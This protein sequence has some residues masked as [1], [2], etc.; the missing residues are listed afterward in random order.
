MAEIGLDGHIYLRGPLLPYTN[1]GGQVCGDATHRW[2][3]VRAVTVTQG[4]LGFEEKFCTVCDKPFKIGDAV[5]LRVH[6]IE[7]DSVLTVPK[8]VRC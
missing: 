8:H 3:L 7:K 6:K 4:D 2:T 1:D 5:N